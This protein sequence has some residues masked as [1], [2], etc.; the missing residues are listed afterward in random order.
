MKTLFTVGSH[1]IAGLE[2]LADAP[3]P[4][5]MITQRWEE[6]H[7]GD[8]MRE[9]SMTCTLL[10]GTVGLDACLRTNAVPS[11]LV[12]ALIPAPM[13]ATHSLFAHRLQMWLLHCSFA[14]GVLDRNT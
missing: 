4:P 10:Y 5:A 14:G 2:A 8:S 1:G 6:C 11:R 3:S 13:P 7:C 12:P 9:L